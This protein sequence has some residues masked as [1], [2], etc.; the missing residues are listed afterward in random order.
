MRKLFAILGVLIALVFIALLV[1]PSFVN[2]NQYH[3]RIQAELQSRLG[4]RVALGNMRL[5]LLPPKFR[6]DNVQVAVT[7]VSRLRAHSPKLLQLDVA[8]K[9][10]PLLHKDV[11]IS[12][13]TLNRPTIELI[14]N[15][16]GAWNFST[17]GQTPATAPQP[18]AQRQAPTSGRAELRAR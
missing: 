9:L 11:E 14:K 3:D 13:L 2:V 4:R 18:Q 17:I 1:L 8:V 12:S 10:L 7:R 15:A 6:V 16:R 5:S